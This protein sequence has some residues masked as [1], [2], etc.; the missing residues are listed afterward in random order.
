MDQVLLVQSD[1]LDF[2]ILNDDLVQWSSKE[3]LSPTEIIKGTYIVALRKSRQEILVLSTNTDQ[4]Q[5]IRLPCIID[6]LTVS[7]SGSWIVGVTSQSLYIWEF[8]SGRVAAIVPQL[9]ANI[10]CVKFSSDE[11]LLIVGREDGK[12][13]GW[14]I[15]NL[16]NN[17][18]QPSIVFTKSHTEKITDLIIGSNGSNGSLLY[19][20]SLDGTVK[21]W[22]LQSLEDVPEYTYTLPEIVLSLAL[23]PAERIIYA[24]LENGEICV[25]N[26]FEV[27][28]SSGLV[29]HLQ[30]INMK[31][32]FIKSDDNV[33]MVESSKASPIVSLD[34]SFDGTYLIAGFSSGTV[35]I[36]NTTTKTIKSEYEVS[37]PVRKVQLF[38]EEDSNLS[39]TLPGF[40]ESEKQAGMS[41]THD[42]WTSICE[43]SQSETP[44]QALQKIKSEAEVLA[45]LD[46]DHDM[47]QKILKIESELEKIKQ[48]IAEAST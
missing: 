11:S 2:N 29:Q 43:L 34:V 7:S 42:V 6:K 38:V 27:D 8:F 36:F 12:L 19:S 32:E 10:T 5:T 40:F 41:L 35:A 4:K 15:Q 24:G 33:L 3:D 23:D 28:I 1:S 45:L 21:V 16:I 37:S 22:N 47:K 17:N 30:G 20:A 13:E 46:P 39:K 31:S 26:R 14:G 25:I 18:N 9:E 48:N 44:S